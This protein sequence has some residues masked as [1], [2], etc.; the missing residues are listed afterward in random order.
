MTPTHVIP[1]TTPPLSVFLGH[2]LHV[3]FTV[4]GE[5]RAH[6]ET[7]LLHKSQNDKV[8]VASGRAQEFLNSWANTAGLVLVFRTEKLIH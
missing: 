1:P 3:F 7:L 5:L 6:I 8:R 4:V 2:M